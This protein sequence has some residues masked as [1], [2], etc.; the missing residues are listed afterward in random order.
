MIMMVCVLNTIAIFVI[1][2]IIIVICSVI[3]ILII[4]PVQILKRLRKQAPI[5]ND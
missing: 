2:I 1:I 3:I 5:E 4:V